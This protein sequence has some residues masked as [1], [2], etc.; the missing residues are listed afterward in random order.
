[1]N[2]K[3][4]VL[5]LFCVR[6]VGLM[7][8]QFVRWRARSNPIPE[9]VADV[10]DKTEY[11][12]WRAYHKEKD[13]LDMADTVS[14]F[15]IYLAL[16]WFDVFARVAPSTNPY[17][18][19]AQLLFFVLTLDALKGVAFNYIS[20]M[21]I[22]EKYGFN[23]RTMRTFLMDELKS[24]LISTALTIALVCVFIAFDLALG[25]LALPLFAG[26]LIAL[27]LLVSALY[28]FLSRI[29][30][31]FTPLEEGELRDKLTALLEKN[32]Y[33][34][35]A[36]SVMD[37]SRRDARANAYFTGF[38]R[39]KTIVLYDTLL[40]ALSTDEIVA[41][42]AHELGHGLNRDTL[43]TL[44]LSALQLVLLAA[45]IFLIVRTEAI[46]PDFGFA[47]IQYGFA[48]VL[49]LT[50]VAGLLLPLYGILVN[51]V[52]RRAEYRADAHAVREGYGPMQIAALKKLSR[53][54]LSDLAPSGL[55]IALEYSHPTLSQRIAAI[56]REMDKQRSV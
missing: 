40:T 13:L 14:G 21:K 9:N 38:G 29:N 35:R 1:M 53:D 32:G 19:A 12:R 15:L 49:T 27:V 36:I 7:A 25:A 54:S 33:H 20:A 2:F 24:W 3:T 23:K 28:P 46:Y 42:F 8:L 11:A 51:A 10:Y 48:L 55:E 37:G 30:N 50:V 56:E 4:L 16:I 22:D 52:M 41:V 18:G 47:G 26:I 45:S 34:V 39:T 6:F 44:P 17:I 43:K 5:I 31:K